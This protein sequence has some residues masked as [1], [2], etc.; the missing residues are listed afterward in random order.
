MDKDGLQATIGRN[1]A[2]YRQ[3]AGLT[4]AEL[5]EKI[6]VSIAFISRVERGSKMMKVEHLYTTAQVLNVSCDALFC[7]DSYVSNFENIRFIVDSIPTEYLPGIE[8]LIR[9]CAEDFCPKQKNFT[10]L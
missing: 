10:D 9:V 7:Q 6:G 4:Q 2:R 1:I 5:A 3:E 8:K